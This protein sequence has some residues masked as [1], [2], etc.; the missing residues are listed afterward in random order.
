MSVSEEYMALTTIGVM[1]E[2][3]YLAESLCLKK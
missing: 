1:G 2:K 3:N